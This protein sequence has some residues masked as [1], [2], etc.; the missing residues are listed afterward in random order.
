MARRI[1]SLCTFIL[2]AS[3]AFAFDGLPPTHPLFGVQTRVFSVVHQYWYC[4]DLQIAYLKNPTQENL[5]K[6]DAATSAFKRQSADLGVELRASLRSG[7]QTIQLVA[8][9][10]RSLPT[11]AKPCLFFT[12]GALRAE[13]MHPEAA[14]QTSFAF[15]EYFPGYGYGD[16]KYKY[17]KGREVSRENKGTTWQEESRTVSSQFNAEL[18]IELS[19]LP[20]LRNMETAG[21]IRNLKVGQQ[22]EGAVAG[23]PTLLVKVSFQAV[24]SVEIKAHRR[25]EVNKIWF[26]LYRAKIGLWASGP[27][28][29]CGQ[30]YEILNE[31]TGDAV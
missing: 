26:E 4:S 8:E 1:V 7:T 20:S 5:A 2:F 12:L 27:W 22:F 25:Y 3:S 29:L 28:E 15:E 9:I 24:R 23:Q 31:P 19:L 14:G 13:S 21:T 17:R 6:S 16:P 10:Y 30:T 18:V 11:G